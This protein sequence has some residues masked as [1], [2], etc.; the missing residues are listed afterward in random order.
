MHYLPKLYAR[1]FAESVRAR[2]SEKE[3]V[4][5]VKSFVAAVQRHCDGEN[6]KKIIAETERVIREKQGI[7]TVTLETARPQKFDARAL[8]GKFLEKS[9][10]V[11]T[12]IK[13]NLVAGV[14]II[15]NDERELD[16]TLRRKLTKL[17]AS[18]NY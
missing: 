8:F 11:E 15:V 16:M 17:F 7:R 14:K 13:K 6:L 12:R 3:K 1:A 9:D 10:V 4:A 2:M 18:S 5:L